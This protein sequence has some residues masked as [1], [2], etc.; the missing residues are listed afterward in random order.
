M[1]GEKWTLDT[2]ERYL[3]SRIDDLG[4]RGDD[5]EKMHVERFASAKERVDLAIAASD[6]AI[7][8]AEVAS[9]KRFES[10]NE[11]RK[12]LSD[13]VSTFLPRTEYAVQHQALVEKV[14]IATATLSK[15]S[16]A[17][18]GR[19]RGVS[20]VGFIVMAVITAIASLAGIGSF[21]FVAFHK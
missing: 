12:A 9:D 7:I 15:M 13:N 16:S 20:T 2:L 4:R 18:E 14:D 6:K 8:K 3:S 17:A 1:A 5:R 21:L 19:I 11:F 10:V